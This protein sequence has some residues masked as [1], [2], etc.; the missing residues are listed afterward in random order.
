VGVK[1]TKQKEIREGMVKQ[2]GY[3]KLS[4]MDASWHTDQM[5]SY[6]RSQGMVIRVKCPDCEWSQFGEEAVGMTPCY[7]CNSTSYIIKPLIVGE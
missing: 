2:I 4:T 1:M 7:S 6:L 3:I 5:L